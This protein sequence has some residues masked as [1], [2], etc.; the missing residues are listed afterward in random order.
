MQL[1]Q[2]KSQGSFEV[3]FLR[4]FLHCFG[5]VGFV[6]PSSRDSP[7]SEKWGTGEH[8]CTEV[9][10]QFHVPILVCF[11]FTSSPHSE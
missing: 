10:Q 6:F 5:C 1:V 8:F 2:R 4:F 11:L 9:K 7:A 3:C